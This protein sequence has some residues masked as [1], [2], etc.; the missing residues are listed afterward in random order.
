MKSNTKANQATNNVPSTVRP[1]DIENS[2]STDSETIPTHDDGSPSSIANELTLSNCAN[3]DSLG[4]RPIESSTSVITN[5][6]D[7]A[8]PKA[9]KKPKI[10]PLQMADISH[11]LTSESPPIYLQLAAAAIL[12]ILSSGVEVMTD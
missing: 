8:T 10:A 12:I 11:C 1:V 6:V 7:T 9:K 5:S 4:I 3:N 2:I